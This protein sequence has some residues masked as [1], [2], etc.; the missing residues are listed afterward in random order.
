VQAAS[1]RAHARA[2]LTGN[3]SDGYGGRT[4]AVCIRDF[5]A[6]AHVAPAAAFALEAPGQDAQAMEPL[7]RAAVTRFAAVAQRPAPAAHVRVTTTIP[8]QL[9]LAGSS[10]IVIAVLRALAAATDTALDERTLARE[11]LKAETE[12]LG[13]AA[14]PQDRLVQAFEGLLYMD[15]ADDRHEPLDPGLLPPLFVAHRDEDGEPSQTLH[16]GLRSRHEAG[17]AAVHAGMRRLAEL[18]ATARAALLAGDA[19]TFAACVSGSFDVR[20][21][22]VEVDE[23]ERRGIDVARAHGLHANYAGSGGAVVGLLGDADPGALAAAYARA[24]WRIV[25]PARVA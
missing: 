9:G 12:E 24:G 17:D 11:A 18:T 6:E 23:R 25:A 21:S 19:E 20:A 10:A 4:L 3:P 15:F 14:G 1:G 5:A 22:M 7:V 16:R 2:A 8:R 13:I